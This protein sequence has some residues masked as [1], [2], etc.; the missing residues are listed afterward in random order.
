M[1]EVM[2]R[3]VRCVCGQQY[4]WFDAQDATKL[5]ERH[6]R[7]CDVAASIDDLEYQEREKEWRNYSDS[8][9]L[10]PPNPCD[11]CGAD[12]V[13]GQ[14]MCAVCGGMVTEL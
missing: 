10:G 6:A 14:V 12:N 2:E 8:E 5:A 9:P 11:N 4:G 1:S 13:Q 7:R 3:S